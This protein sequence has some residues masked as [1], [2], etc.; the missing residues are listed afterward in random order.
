LPEGHLVFAIDDTPTK[1]AG[2]MVEGAGI[3][4]NPTPGPAD[5]KFLYGHVWV[6]ISVTIHGVFL[7][8]PTARTLTQTSAKA[9]ALQ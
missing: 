1:R 4:H 2:P 6:T 3:H 5:Q 7:I 8:I 9:L